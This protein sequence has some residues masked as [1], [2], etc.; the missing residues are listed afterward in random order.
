MERER[1]DTYSR[2]WLQWCGSRKWGQDVT[3]LQRSRSPLASLTSPQ[4]V[5]I[6]DGCSALTVSVCQNV[7]T[8]G[9]LPWPTASWYQCHASGLM[10]SPTDPRTFRLERSY[11]GAGK[12]RH[13]EI[14]VTWSLVFS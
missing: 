4:C 8:T 3:P 11:L 9:H 6:R 10:G 12:G 1:L 2:A 5:L 13:S 14:L 7:S